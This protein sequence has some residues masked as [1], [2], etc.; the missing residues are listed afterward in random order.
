M[1]LGFGLANHCGQLGA[2]RT[3]QFSTKR[4]WSHLV[5]MPDSRSNSSGSDG[6]KVAPSQWH[7]GD[8]VLTLNELQDLTD[9]VNA[10]GDGT[11]VF[12]IVVGFSGPEGY[13]LPHRSGTHQRVEE[14]FDHGRNG[15][16]Y[17]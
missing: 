13:R 16:V 17:E 4:H 15:Y 7:S 14:M 5:T 2:D 8:G 12:N 1:L 10:V 3:I 6:G 9:E 11:N